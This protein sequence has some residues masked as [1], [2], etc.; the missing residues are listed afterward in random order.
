MFTRDD[1]IKYV[2]HMQGAPPGG[3]QLGVG[4]LDFTHVEVLIQ[5]FNFIGDFQRIGTTL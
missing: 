5:C 4:T 3:K 1:S 2:F